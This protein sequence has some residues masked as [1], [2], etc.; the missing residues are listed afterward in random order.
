[1]VL[2]R[3]RYTHPLLSA[4]LAMLFHIFISVSV[5]SSLCI[6]TAAPIS[7]LDT[8]KG[9]DVSFRRYNAFWGALKLDFSFDAI[10]KRNFCSNFGRKIEA[11][12]R[13]QNRGLQKLVLYIGD[14]WKFDIE[15]ANL[16][17]QIKMCYPEK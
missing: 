13:R 2:K 17:S 6:R 15:Y 1:M 4:Q 5:L 7:S 16:P 10:L 12:N 11:E 14:L 8:T 9:V 3:W